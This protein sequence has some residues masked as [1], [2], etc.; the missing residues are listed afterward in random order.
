MPNFDIIK[1]VNVASTFRNASVIGMFDLKPDAQT[2]RFAGSFE[3]PEGWQIGVIVGNSG[4]GKSTIAKELFGANFIEGGG[5]IPKDVSI[6][7]AMPVGAGMQEITATFNAVGFSSPPSWL[8]PYDVLSNGQ[9]MRADLAFHILEERPLI[10]FDEFT[11]VVDRTVA[12]IGSFAVQKAIRRTKKQFVAVTCHF[13]VIPWLMP[14]WV[15]DTND[16][17]FRVMSEKKNDPT[18]A[19][20]YSKQKINQSGRCLQSTII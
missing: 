11:S 3:F 15:F 8:K 12:Q 17:T 5:Q 1:T 19:S 6:V 7:D 9:K 16:M 20:T 2:E 10:A 18:F 14:D 4:T 13:D